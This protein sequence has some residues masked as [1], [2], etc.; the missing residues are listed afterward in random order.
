MDAYSNSRDFDNNYDR[1]QRFQQNQ[2]GRNSRKRS[3]GKIALTLLLIALFITAYLAI[4]LYV[5]NDLMQSDDIAYGK[6]AVILS[7]TSTKVSNIKQITILIFD[8]IGKAIPES[9]CF[10]STSRALTLKDEQVP[11]PWWGLAIILGGY[12]GLKLTEIDGCSS[13]I[14]KA[15]QNST[16]PIHIHASDGSG[17]MQQTTIHLFNVD[18]PVNAYA[19]QGGLVADGSTQGPCS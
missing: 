5:Q 14:T 13:T 7:A 9:T 17:Q 15:R 6:S 11:T 3:G 4:S 10:I 1:R 19:T 16:F 12:Q 18:Q 2:R 8:K